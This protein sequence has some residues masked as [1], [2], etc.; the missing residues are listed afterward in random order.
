LIS[1]EVSSAVGAIGIDP[2]RTD[3]LYSADIAIVIGGDGAMLSAAREFAPYG[4]PLIGINTG[5]LGLL[6]QLEVNDIEFALD[7]LLADHCEFDDRIMLNETAFRDNKPIASFLALNDVVV[8]KGALA[9]IINLT[10]YINNQLITSY[11]ADGLIVATPTGSTAYSLSAGGPIVNPSIDAILL[12]PICAHTLN[13]RSILASGKEQIRVV[14]DSHH[15]ELM[16][17]IDGQIGFSLKSKDYIVIE[18]SDVTAKLMDVM[19]R[20]FYT[21]VRN[22]IHEGR[23]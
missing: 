21:L 17:T 19:Q 12:T 10:T 5:H 3:Q 7:K 14:V 13:S 22:R 2:V 11:R 20:G 23:L 4:I 9:R 18:K 15:D 6:T 8:T 1:E 16:L